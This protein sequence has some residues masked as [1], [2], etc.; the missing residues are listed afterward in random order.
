MATVQGRQS[1]WGHS[2]PGGTSLVSPGNASRE[3]MST[4]LDVFLPLKAAWLREGSWLVCVGSCYS[5]KYK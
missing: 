3:G 5:G 1:A 2:C 4:L